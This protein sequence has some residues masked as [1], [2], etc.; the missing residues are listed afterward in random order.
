M[1]SEISAV[2]QLSEDKVSHQV[3]IQTKIT[4]VR[5]LALACEELS[6]KLVENGTQ[7][8]YSGT[9]TAALV[10][11]CKGPYDIAATKGADGNYTLATDWWNGH[12]AKEVGT[13]YSKLSQIYGVHKATLEAKK[14]GYFVTRTVNT[15]GQPR[16]VITGMK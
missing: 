7:R 15:Q 12:V 11:K 10:I 3:T 5:A 8:T 13:N 1:E 16:L 2:P 14:K 6:L 9:A 4:D